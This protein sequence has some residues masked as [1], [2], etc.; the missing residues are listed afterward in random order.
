ME[1]PKVEFASNVIAESELEADNK[2]N[3]VPFADLV[4]YTHLGLPVR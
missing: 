2:F 3:V 4:W 1:Y